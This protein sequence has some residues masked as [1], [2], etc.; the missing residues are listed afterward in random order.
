[1]RTWILGVALL[2]TACGG[3]GGSS[4]PA[5]QPVEGDVPE[6][7]NLIVSP[8]T[9]KYMQGDGTV[10]AKAEFEYSD[11]DLDIQQMQ[12]EMSDGSS[13][14]I[15][16]GSIPTVHGT[17]IEE[18]EVSTAESG[19]CTVDIWL[20]DAA[21][22]AS[23]HLSADILVQ[24]APPEIS[25]LLL[26][27]ETILH[28]AGDGSIDATATFD[29]FDADLDIASM[30]VEMSDGTSQ[31]IPLGP[32]DTASGTLTEEF[33]VSTVEPGAITVDIWLVDALGNTSNQL[34]A[35]IGIQ[36]EAD[37]SVWLQRASGLPNILNDVM[38]NGFEFLA[39]GDGGLIMRSEDGIAWSRVNSGTTVN[40]NAI[41][42]RGLG[43]IDYFVVGDQGT[44][45]RSGDGENWEPTQGQGPEDVSLRA[46]GGYGFN[47]LIVAGKKEGGADT[48]FIMSSVDRGTTWMIAE[49]LPQSGRSVTG[50][51]QYMDL[52]WEG[53][54]VVA[55]T[56]IENYVDDKDARVL[57][58]FDGSTWIEVV[59]STESI[60]TYSILHDGDQF[61]AAGRVGRMYTSA[62][63]INWFEH[64]TSAG[65]TKFRALAQSDISLI[66]DG[67]NEFYGWGPMDA[68]GT[69]TFDS[70]K[71]W[72]SFAVA[73]G[74]DT[75]GLAWGN[76]RFVSVGCAGSDEE[77]VGLDQ[78]EGAI[79]ST[80]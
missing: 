32:I 5:S 7:A 12:I 69:E 80:P 34:S 76:G 19:T 52:D 15:P 41:A 68:T 45:I 61:W 40:L 39:V 20:V 22:H 73:A 79:F 51:Q 37:A 58:S 70:G 64:Q 13:Q 28:M 6:I 4:A 33:V 2:L 24:S 9:V 46:I 17:M 31:T 71:T 57:V 36:A 67:E 43:Y 18:F 65:G 54:R 14:T 8:E 72:T 27:P 3:G 55:T 77:C 74:Y 50:L 47:I 48:A 23:N 49:D 10:M 21:G 42:H 1:M 35:E 66:A 78:G 53:P 30:Q 63:G 62:D 44:V 38:W 16:L 26:S 75:R 59:L 25:N 11:S 56:Q 29:Y 60:A